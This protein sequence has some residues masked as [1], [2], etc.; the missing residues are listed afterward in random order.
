[1]KRRCVLALCA[2]LTIGSLVQAGFRDTPSRGV[3]QAGT[4]PVHEWID[5]G[6]AQPTVEL[7]PEQIEGM[8]APTGGDWIQAIGPVAAFLELQEP[9]VEALVQL[10]I[11]RQLAV[12]PLALEIKQRKAL[13][14]ELFQ[15]GE[16]NPLAVGQLVIQIRLLHGAI[17]AV[18]VEF[19]TAFHDLLFPGQQEKLGAIHVAAALQPILPAFKGLG[20]I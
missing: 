2:L 3:T 5:D 1:M 12:I 14:A 20:L 7:S 17:A 13:L 19:L 8:V 18:Q 10:L 9:Q 15:S 11:Q 6:W 16:P 4:D